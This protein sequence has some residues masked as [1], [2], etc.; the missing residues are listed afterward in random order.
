MHEPNWHELDL[1]ILQEE[2]GP[3]GERIVHQR[4]SILRAESE[5]PFA[6]TDSFQIPPSW[7]AGFAGDNPHVAVPYFVELTDAEQRKWEGTIDFRNEVPR[8][9][10]RRVKR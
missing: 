5:F 7:L 4:P 3:A 1:N 9:Q 8:L 6:S 2:L 10:F